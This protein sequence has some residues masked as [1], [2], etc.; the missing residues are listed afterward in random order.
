MKTGR[1]LRY[2]VEAGAALGGADEEQTK[3][4][5]SYSRRIGIAFQIA[6][7]ILDVT[8]DERTMGKT[9]H[10]DE[11]QNKLT[12]VSLYGLENARRIAAEL[13][14]VTTSPSSAATPGI[15][16]TWPLI[17]LNANIEGEPGK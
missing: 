17:L 3:A 6:D 4:L 7:D 16:K 10:K 14:A 2:A 1:L 15:C 5:I 13:T 8:G 9:L 12:F 11:K